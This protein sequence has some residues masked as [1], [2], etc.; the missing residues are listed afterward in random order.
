M[1]LIYSAR[2]NWIPRHFMWPQ[3]QVILLFWH[4]SK[5]HYVHCVNYTSET[6]CHIALELWKF[7]TYLFTVEVL[8]IAVSSS[9]LVGW[10]WMWLQLVEV[11]LR[12]EAGEQSAAD[13]YSAS[14]IPVMD[15]NVLSSIP[16]VH[17][18][19][20]MI[21]CRVHIFSQ[22][23]EAWPNCVQLLSGHQQPMVRI[24]RNNFRLKM[25]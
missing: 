2:I 20:S 14:A 11:D 8:H 7:L 13:A 16:A 6:R 25:L 19:Y 15:M 4:N 18:T 1:H 12:F 10:L 22:L 9:A 21:R 24:T 17:L 5:E 3:L 23:V